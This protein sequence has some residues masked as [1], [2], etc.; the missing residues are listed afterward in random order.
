MPAQ[1]RTQ[2]STRPASAALQAASSAH[3]VLAGWDCSTA[4]GGWI[5]RVTERPQ[6]RCAKAGIEI[7][8][9]SVGDCYDKE[10]VSYCTS[11]G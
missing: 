6:Q 3:L 9:G 10:L 7:S 2:V 4:D 11:L 8:M 5:D 1:L